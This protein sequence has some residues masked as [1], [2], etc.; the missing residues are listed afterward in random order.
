MKKIVNHQDRTVHIQPPQTY[1]S[2]QTTIKSYADNVKIGRPPPTVEIPIE[3]AVS[4]MEILGIIK[5]TS[6][7][8]LKLLEFQ[9]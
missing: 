1:P 2:L 4:T 5:K 9:R 7:H 6:S 3:P 8:A